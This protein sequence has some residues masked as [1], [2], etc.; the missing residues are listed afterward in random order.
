MEKVTDEKPKKQVYKVNGVV[1]QAQLGHF[2][3]RAFRMK[4]KVEGMVMLNICSCSHC[5]M[6][7]EGFKI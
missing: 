1:K 4:E 6:H 7:K 2:Q 3:V 5:H